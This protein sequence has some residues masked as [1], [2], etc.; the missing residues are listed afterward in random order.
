MALHKNVEVVLVPSTSNGEDVNAISQD[1]AD[2]AGTTHS[3]LLMIWHEPM[4]SAVRER[5][6][7]A[8]SL[9]TGAIPRQGGAGILSSETRGSIDILHN[10]TPHCLRIRLSYD[11]RSGIFDLV[12][13]KEILRNVLMGSQ[14][15]TSALPNSIVQFFAWDENLFHSHVQE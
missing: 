12:L 1:A 10:T 9:D 5:A 15:L 7:K 2:T 8:G 3:P 14:P 13:R 11:R 6:E 4:G